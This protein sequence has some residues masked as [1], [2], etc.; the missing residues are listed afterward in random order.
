MLKLIVSN[1][2]PSSKALSQPIISPNRCAPFTS[3]V[4]LKGPCLY[5]M[6]VQDPSHYLSCELVLEVE[7]SQQECGGGTVICHFPNI[8][9]EQLRNFICEDE[10]LYGIIMIQFQMKVLEQLLLFCATHYASKLIIYADNAQADEF[11][12]YRDFLSYEGQIL[13][14]NGEQTEMI[15]PADPQTFD[16]WID[17]MNDVTLKFRQTLW[18]DQR[19]NLTIKHY[20]KIHPLG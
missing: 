16:N 1:A 4:W 3:E 6:M 12:I 9:V 8:E 14:Q 5:L 11:E 7:E 10:T 20:L 15:I 18:Q 17:F 13:T 2:E 19:T